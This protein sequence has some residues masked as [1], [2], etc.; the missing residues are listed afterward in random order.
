[1]HEHSNISVLDL[2]RFDSLRT[3][4]LVSL[5]LHYF[6]AFQFIAPEIAIRNYSLSIYTNGVVIGLAEV[7]GSILC[8]FIIDHFARKKVIYITQTICIATSVPVFIF[9]AC[10]DGNCPMA[11]KILQIAGLFIFRFAAT[12]AYN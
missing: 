2:F 9:F 12:V 8:Y 10:S 6:A 7:F 1:M 3:L 11:T 4:T 5:V